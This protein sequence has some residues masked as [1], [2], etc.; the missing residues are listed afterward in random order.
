[1]VTRQEAIDEITLDLRST[2][3][4]T[5]AQIRAETDKLRMLTLRE[6]EGFMLLYR[7]NR[8]TVPK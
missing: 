7:H 6:L 5:D 2:G 3:K 1:M 4:Y 8:V